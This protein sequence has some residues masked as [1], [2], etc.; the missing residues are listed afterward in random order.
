MLKIN[1]EKLVMQSVCGEISHP[2]ARSYRF[3]TEGQ[4]HM[5]PGTG[6]ITYN[7]KVGD[8]ASGWKGDHVE[9]GVSIQLSD[10]LKNSGLNCMACVGNE[11]KVISGEAKGKKGV[12]TGFH[13]GIEHT[14]I[15]F[16]DET[17]DKLAIGDKIQIK[18][19]G[20]GLEIENYEDIKTYNLDPAL[21]EKMG[22]KQLED[23]SL[24]VDVVTEVPARLM[25]S[26]I[27]SPAF[28]GDYDIQTADP[29]D[30]K[31]F[32]LDKLRLGDIVLLRDC[33]TT[34]SRG[35]LKGAVTIGVVIHSDCII[36]GHGPGVS[37]LLTC[38]ESKIK[39]NQNP[40]ANIANYL[41]LK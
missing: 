14:L 12:V 30:Y 11:A 1:K 25:G 3:D 40:K 20:N 16:D 7:V 5:V 6:G 26:G 2:R 4:S 38:K 29:E 17:L 21:F 23:G 8:Y 28:R 31:K 33:D 34:Y 18:S 41:E 35:Y 24:Q 22:I 13:G 27:G 10:A 9:P 37:T 19:V 39:G 36:G 15:H 32:G